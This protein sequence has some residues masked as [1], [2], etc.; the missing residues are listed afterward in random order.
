[1]TVDQRIDDAARRRDKCE[2]I[3]D[4]IMRKDGR[5][6]D[7]LAEELLLAQLDYAV[8]KDD[9]SDPYYKGD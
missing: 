9:R 1:M 6:P 3:I 8:A 5:I 4:N 7:S 2:A